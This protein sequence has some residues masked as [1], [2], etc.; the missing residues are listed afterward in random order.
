[1]ARRPLLPVA[2]A[3]M[4]GVL[5]Q[6]WL[7]ADLKWLWLCVLAVSATAAGIFILLRRDWSRR[8]ALAAMLTLLVAAGALLDLA[9]DPRHDIRHWTHGC[10]SYVCMELR[11]QDT[12]QPRTRSYR[13]AAE[14]TAVDGRPRQGDITLYLR[15][16]S[17]AAGLRYGDRLLLHG[18]PDVERRSVYATADHYLLT[19]RNS[20]S[21]R[22]RSEALRMRLLRRMQ[23]G[24]LQRGGVA[25]A[26]TLGWRGDLGDDTQARFRDA[27]I[28][29]LLAV[30]GLH[31]G[32][33]A[34]IVGVALFW[35]GRERRGRIV[36]G[37]AQLAAVW[38]FALLTGMAPSTLRAALM[39]SLLIVS[40][41]LA[42]R[43]DKLNLLAATAVA[44]LVVKPMLLFDVGWQLSFS[45]VGGI[46]LAMPAIEAV[47][48]WWMQA[49]A[50]STA[51]M[52]AT[53]P[54][55]MATFHRLPIYFLIANVLIVPLAGVLLGLS[56]LYMALPYGLTAW[57]LDL[58]LHATEVLTGWV[59]DLPGAVVK[60]IDASTPALVGVGAL[61]VA[62]LLL[63]Q[64]IF[65]GK[66]D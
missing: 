57:P 54:V 48:R 51:A 31:V 16:D 65:K 40:D 25:E 36:R 42:R 45:A 13:V 21:L 4:G 47:R 50:A 1:M 33:L 63:P 38:G 11:L 6:H 12:P 52:V 59:Q 24:P 37:G 35:T 62:V 10:N 20:T 27:G 30:S 53:L 46:L 22:A 32:L 56:L 29:H 58:L 61:V 43:T 17:V 23:Q 60:G 18:W 55:V 28:A 49:A 26:M 64:L 8:A 7:E 19:G 9:S 41:V 3:L 5:V 2:L 15:K 14:V 39:F 66:R 44:M 34:G